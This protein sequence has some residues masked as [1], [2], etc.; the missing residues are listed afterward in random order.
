[1]ELKNRRQ[2]PGE[3]LQELL[4]ME[5]K[6]ITPMPSVSGCSGKFSQFICRIRDEDTQHSTR[7]MEKDLKSSSAY[8]MGN[9]RPRELLSR[10]SDTSDQWGRKITYM[11]RDDKINSSSTGLKNYKQNGRRTLLRNLNVTSAEVNKK[12]H[13]EKA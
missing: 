1:M 7:F 3:S 10:H 2:K 8:S 4:L 12:G 9:M 11:E 6:L 5:R 13:V